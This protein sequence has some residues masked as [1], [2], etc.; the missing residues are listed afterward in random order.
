MT[1][2]DRY[3]ECCI[4]KGIKPV[5]QETADRIGCSKANISA[6]S[7]SGK[8]PRGDLVA[9]TARMLEVSADYLL[10]L[11]NEPLPIKSESGLSIDEKRILELSHQ[12]N[13]EGQKVALAMLSGLTSSGLFANT[14]ENTEI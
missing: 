8:T 3:F 2:Y 6:L 12:L 14:L 1:F 10:G 5:S 9:E 4:R 11:I 7:K 13:A